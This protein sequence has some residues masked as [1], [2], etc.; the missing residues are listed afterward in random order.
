MYVA[1]TIEEVREQVSAARLRGGLVGFVPTMGALHAGHISLVSAAKKDC[2]FVVVSIFVNPTQF[3]PNEDYDRYPRPAEADTAACRDAGVDLLFMPA[4]DTIYPPGEK[5]ETILPPAG[6]ADNLCGRSRPG[7]FA[8][9]CTVVA[10]LFDIVRP[11]KAYFG[12]KDFQQAAI[13]SRMVRDR[14]IPVDV[15]VCPIV[16]EADGLAMSSRNAYLSPEHRRQAA[17]LYKSLQMAA[18]MIRRDHPP[19]GKVVRAISQH[20]AVKAPAG[21]IDY[22]QIVNPDDLT[23][24]KTTDEAV[25]VALAVRFGQTRLIDNILVD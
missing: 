13:I 14:R 8:G 16:R 20:I 11:D 5:L 21:E 24:V 3:G 10:R 17:E 9:V 18:D 1:R 12:A 2:A 23:D 25:L 15:V 19:A 4:V 7:H 22:V 6:L